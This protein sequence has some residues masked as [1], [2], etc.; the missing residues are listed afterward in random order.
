MK[1]YQIII[2]VALVVL[3]LLVVF[4]SQAKAAVKSVI[5]T[6]SSTDTQA[7]KDICDL[8]GYFVQENGKIF[9]LWRD[10]GQVKKIEV[11]LYDQGF[12]TVNSNVQILTDAEYEA[13]KVN[14]Y[15]PNY[16]WYRDDMKTY[17]NK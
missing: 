15:T 2:V 10:I 12:N 8:T 16:Q 3:I 13:G 4:G 6:G 7:A 5:G 14:A 11:T 9:K 17:C 1:P